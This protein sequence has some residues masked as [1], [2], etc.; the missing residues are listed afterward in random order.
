M[1]RERGTEGTG[2]AEGT[3]HHRTGT[4]GWQGGGRM[5]G[6]LNTREKAL[7][8]RCTSGSGGVVGWEVTGAG[9]T[10]PEGTTWGGS[11]RGPRGNG[12]GGALVLR[13]GPR[14]TDLSRVSER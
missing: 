2:H 14:I 3:D 9:A 4:G 1:G 13:G 7:V 5:G 11:R 6:Q 12:A 8:H 10:A